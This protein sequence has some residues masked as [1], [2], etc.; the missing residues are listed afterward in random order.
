MVIDNF[1]MNIDNGEI[2]AILGPSGCGK[3][4]ILRLIAG[5]EEP[6]LGEIEIENKVVVNEEKFIQPENRSVGMVFQDYALFPHLNIYENIK[7][8]LNK[9][10]KEEQKDIVLNMIKLVNLQGYEKRYPYELSGG[11]QQRV[12]LARALAPKPLVLL[13]DEPF[14]NLDSH[15]RGKIREELKSIIKK[16]KTTCIFV[17]HDIEDVNAISDR[18]IQL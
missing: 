15:L 1:S 12:A 6:I 9:F 13:M 16:S 3:S 14:S 2:V 17:T 7:F 8:G 18:V 10:S 5:L 4:T 11:Q